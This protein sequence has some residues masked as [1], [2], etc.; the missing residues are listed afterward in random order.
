MK[1]SFPW[2]LLEI[3]LL[4]ILASCTSTS[5]SP[6]QSNFSGPTTTLTSTLTTVPEP[7]ITTISVP[8]HDMKTS[9]PF[10][11]LSNRIIYLQE[12]NLWALNPETLQNQQLT[13]D[14]ERKG[15]WAVGADMHLTP[16]GQLIYASRTP[17][18]TDTP[19]IT[20][21]A[22]DPRCEKPLTTPVSYGC[23]QIQQRCFGFR[24][25]QEGRYLAYTLIDESKPAETRLLDLPTG[26][27]EVI[28]T[29]EI[30]QR[31]LKTGALLLSTPHCEG[32]SAR[33]WNPTTGKVIPL[34]NSDGEWNKT[35][36]AFVGIVV[37]YQGPPYMWGYDFEKEQTLI[38]LD[39]SQYY[40]GSVFWTPQ[41]DGF[42]YTQAALACTDLQNPDSCKLTPRQIWQ[43]NREGTEQTCLA[44]DPAY[45]FDLLA[46]GNGK[47]VVRRLPFIPHQSAPLDLQ[48]LCRNS[49]CPQV[50]YY[51]LDLTTHTW[52]DP[53]ASQPEL[54]NL[55][56]P[57]NSR[58][59]Y[60]AADGSW[61]LQLDEK[62]ITLW[63][64]YNDP[65]PPELITSGA[66]F[67]LVP[68]R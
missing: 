61:S 42:I 50:Q 33:A 43:T 56:L 7:Q 67:F 29:G 39:R 27:T 30:P 19:Q 16:E 49:E 66:Q 20:L 22:I 52:S 47:I 59:L 9:R 3:S 37:P 8:E 38:P 11:T 25:S 23:G 24:F 58:P 53:L 13:F 68:S 46:L 48:A 12:G 5:L 44:S 55:D 60:T 2:L 18:N 45:N 17:F 15:A 6:S 28:G 21:A 36:T 54:Q 32:R 40:A 34:E 26:K 65:R 64:Q 62:G 41:E 31:W 10:Y 1:I 57:Q 35:Q 51:L 14:I 63:R 4:A